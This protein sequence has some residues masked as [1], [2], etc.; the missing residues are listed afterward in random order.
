MD[1]RNKY[2]KS[3]DKNSRIEKRYMPIEKEEKQKSDNSC[4]QK[5]LQN[6][7]K[8]P[9]ASVTN[10]SSYKE[11]IPKYKLAVRDILSTDNNKKK[12]L[13]YVV[14]KRNEQKFIKRNI[15][16]N[17]DDI[18]KS[19]NIYN[20]NNQFLSKTNIDYNSNRNSINSKHNINSNI[21]PK[22]TYQYF[23][24]KRKKPYV[25]PRIKNEK[26]N[27]IENCN[28]NCRS[29][30]NNYNRS[31]NRDNNN[32]T[33]KCIIRNQIITNNSN[34]AS[35]YGSYNNTNYNSKKNQKLRKYQIS[36]NNKEYSSSE[37]IQKETIT[38]PVQT[39]L[40]KSVN[41]QI[42]LVNKNESQ[43][44]YKKSFDMLPFNLNKNVSIYYSRYSKKR[45]NKNNENENS[46]TPKIMFK[47]FRNFRITKNS[48][49][50]K[51]D[52]KLRND[53][54][55]KNKEKIIEINLTN[56][57]ANLELTKKNNLL[58][59][60]IRRNLLFKDENQ[61]ID[62]INANYNHEKKLFLF[63]LQNKENEVEKIN[64]QLSEEINKNKVKTIKK[65]KRNINISEQNA[66]I[67]GIKN[68]NKE[69]IK[70]IEIMKNN[71]ITFKNI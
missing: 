49:Q 48:I 70:S 52:N 21:N 57:M 25:S 5:L 50:L 22:M 1:Y 8:T 43:A 24:D 53:K 64:K 56:E 12:D 33:R 2:L 63:K 51:N 29:N 7:N 20:S 68:N 60:N 45:D 6:S 35:P 15:I 28:L 42:N 36:S 32:Y 71:N 69:M 41:V 66:E 19:N 46:H 44:L 10:L 38:I 37:R 40:R 4:L 31:T 11:N 17:K 61:L 67:S 3:L 34:D 39:K 30:I 59:K 62:Y 18:N 9:K 14:Q 23:V 16:Y 65:I 26:E 27:N 55:R 13:N 54:N 58:K 47:D